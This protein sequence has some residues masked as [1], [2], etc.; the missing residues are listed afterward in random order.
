LFATRIEISGGVA[1]GKTTLCSLLGEAGFHACYENFK[2]NPFWSLFYQSPEDHAFETEITF[3][4]QHYSGIKSAL[5]DAGSLVCDFAMLQDR[6]YADINL[7]AGALDA[8]LAV[9]GQILSELPPPSLIVHLVCGA[10]EEL[11][12]IR[13]RARK[14]EESVQVSYLDA[15]NRSIAHS[16]D[17]ARRTVQVLEIDSQKNDFASDKVTRQRITEMVLDA[18]SGKGEGR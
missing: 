15:L 7:A 11:A 6:A 10:D 8:F 12:R 3:L 5:K 13:R 1:S 14:E 4:L 2:Q 17:D 16:V 18:M 9:Y